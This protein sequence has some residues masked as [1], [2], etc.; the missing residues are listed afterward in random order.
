[1][2]LFDRFLKREV[3][4]SAET[5]EDMINNQVDDVL[6]KALF[7]GETITIE[8]AL[9]L[10]AVS[11]AVDE[12]SNTIASLPIK[13]YKEEIKESSKRNITEQLKDKRIKLLNSDTGDTLDGFQMKKALTKDYL[14]DKGAYVYVER[15]KGEFV[16]LRYTDAQ[17]IFVLKN[18]NAI[19][20]DIKYM[21]DGKQYESYEFLTILRSTKDGGSGIG[22]ITEVSKAI[23]SAYTTLLFELGIVKKGGAKKG[24]LTATK[25]LGKE[26]IKALK[27]AW[28]Q[29]YSNS[30]ENVI[31]LNDGLEFKEASN[32]SVELQLNERKKTLSEEIR[33]IFHINSDYDLYIKKAIIPIIRAIETALNRDL[34]LESEKDSFYFAFDIDEILKGD[35]KARAEYYKTAIDKGWM[36]RNEVRYKED[37]DYVEGL[38]VYSFNLADVLYDP[39]TKK[40]FTPNTSQVTSTN[41]TN[42]G[43]DDK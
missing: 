19:F 23:E 38:D 2:G 15:K 26:E 12:I 16:S 22:L 11:S 35:S 9:S 37:L 31:V 3:E 7:H 6:L 4:Q 43:G 13:L 14:L 29:L 27:D 30:S 17:R 8:N 20:K 40:Y 36:N 39:I 10:P 28:K 33:D 34:L 1:M 42:E 25:K 21:V 18:T 24:F 41:S 5:Q 32:S